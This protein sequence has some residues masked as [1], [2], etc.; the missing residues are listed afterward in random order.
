MAEKQPERKKQVKKKPPAKRPTK[1]APKKAAKKKS[2]KKKSEKKVPKRGHVQ[3]TS[4]QE[5]VTPRPATAEEQEQV[6]QDRETAKEYARDKKK[7]GMLLQGAMEKAE[8]K[9]GVLQK[10]WDDLMTLFRLVRSWV[11]GTYT[12]VPW[13]TIVWIIAA[14]I[15]FVNPFDVIPDFIPGLGYLDDAAVIAFVVNSV[16]DDISHFQA[17]EEGQA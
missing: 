15:Y 13:E 11:N 17:W 6:R 10:V 16:R 12:A 3:H 14:I 7:T 5:A 8:R 4:R 1:R 2:E 9:R